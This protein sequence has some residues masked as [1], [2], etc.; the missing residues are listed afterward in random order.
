MVCRSRD[1]LRKRAPVG[2]GRLGRVLDTFDEQPNITA[3]TF[4]KT[5]YSHSITSKY[6]NK[7]LAPGVKQIP[8]MSRR[9]I[10]GS[11]DHSM[12]VSTLAE[13]RAWSARYQSRTS[14]QGASTGSSSYSYRR[15]ERLNHDSGDEYMDEVTER[16]VSDHQSWSIFRTLAT[17]IRTILTT[18]VTSITSVY[19][20]AVSKFTGRS[21]SITPNARLYQS[22]RYADVQRSWFDRVF[23]QIYLHLCRRLLLDTQLL[24]RLGHYIPRKN[25]NLLALILLPPLLLL[26]WLHSGEIKK[27]CGIFLQGKLKLSVNL[28]IFREI[29]KDV[30]LGWW[31]FTSK[32]EW[33]LI[34]LLGNMTA[35]VASWLPTVPFL[36]S[37]STTYKQLD[38]DM[39]G[40]IV[41]KPALA[42]GGETNDRLETVLAGEQMPAGLFWEQLKTQQTTY[43]IKMEDPRVS[44]LLV[45][46]S[47]LKDQLEQYT[48]HWN[49]WEGYQEKEEIKQQKQGHDSAFLK[50][51]SQSLEAQIRLLK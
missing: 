24:T 29:G 13:R 12:P 25:S 27:H 37:G 8:N 20:S 49:S 5:D 19:Y 26:G 7:E 34:P 2:N 1:R 38:T 16:L 23:L 21:R 9:S 15:Y 51:K 10:H 30:S 40:Q 48:S 33:P 47:I 28:V 50:R 14:S 39:A 42:T 32:Q 36:A 31:L 6:Y 11:L 43:E 46:F 44:R 18:I 17:F 45:E 35:N 4:E 41:S 3:S 22:V